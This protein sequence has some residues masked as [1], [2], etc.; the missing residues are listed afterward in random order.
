MKIL[1]TKDYNKFKKLKG[2]RGITDSRVNKIVSSINKVGYI[3]NPIIVNEKM[4]IIDGQGRFE[5]LK[6]LKLPIYYIIIPGI[7]IEQCISMNINNTNWK[8]MDYID[9]YAEL[10][11]QSFIYFKKLINEYKMYTLDSI[12]ASATGT[13]KA[14]NR[15][16]KGGSIYIDEEMY[17]DAKKVLDYLMDLQLN[18]N[19]NALPGGKTALI[20]CMIELMKHK[21]VDTDLLKEKVLNNYTNLKP[22]S[23]YDNCMLAL[24]DL[25]NRYKK[26]EYISFKAIYRTSQRERKSKNTRI[27][28]SKNNKE[29]N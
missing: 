27:A 18:I 12:Y 29:E 13:L 23:D 10:G 21:K 3:I 22:Y 11:N 15:G 16:I 5:A 4:E 2:N 14:N 9:S 20:C 28:R 6:S 1:E 8:L 25:Y 17:E 26:G 19:E 7:G 24:E